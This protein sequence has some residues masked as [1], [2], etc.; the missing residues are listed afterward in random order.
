VKKVT[1]IGI[2]DGILN[3]RPMRYW[4]PLLDTLANR[5]DLTELYDGEHLIAI[6]HNLKKLHRFEN[7]NKLGFTIL[8]RTEPPSVYPKQYSKSVEKKYDLIIT[9][10]GDYSLQKADNY[11]YPFFYQNIPHYYSYFNSSLNQVIKNNLDNAI[12]TLEHWEKRRNNAV[13]VAANKVS[14]LANSNYNLRR[15][16]IKNKNLIFYGQGWNIAFLKKLKVL[17]GLLK[18]SIENLQWISILALVSFLKPINIKVPEIHNK[19]ELYS[20]SKYVLIIE[21]SNNFLTEKIFDALISGCI[22]I[23]IGPK[24]SNFGINEGLAIQV[25]PDIKQICKTLNSLHLIDHSSYL[26]NIYDFIYS[27]N[28]IKRFD[29][30]AVYSGVVSEIDKIIRA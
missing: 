4:Q 20:N 8:I 19:H 24:L 5:F 16:L 26:K 25:R 3:E 30:N 22:P 2:N 29:G 27:K 1:I 21:N 12:Y 9:P 7:F 6:N 14:P 18:F 10:G 15:K 23:Y 11:L 28:G 17:T 13:I